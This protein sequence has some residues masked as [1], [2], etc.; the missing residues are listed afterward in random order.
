MT[1]NYSWL[2]HPGH[3]QPPDQ[4]FPRGTFL[5]KHAKFVQPLCMLPYP[6]LRPRRPVRGRGDHPRARQA[7]SALPSGATCRA[8]YTQPD[9]DELRWRWR[10]GCFAPR[11][12]MPARRCWL[13]ALGALNCVVCSLA[14]KSLSNTNRSVSLLTCKLLLLGVGP[15]DS[16]RDRRYF[17][18]ERGYSCN[19]VRT[20]SGAVAAGT[21][22]ARSAVTPNLPLGETE[23]GSAPFTYSKEGRVVVIRN[24]PAQ[25]CRQCGKSFHE[26]MWI[27][28]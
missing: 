20:R 12:G 19:S 9:M 27:T 24:V 22:R 11:P 5:L 7:I 1:D 18:A 21:G 13:A 17:G 6:D 28:C 10:D 3:A 4:P 2:E 14:L 23:T 16:Y 15:A 25:V 26:D 8:C